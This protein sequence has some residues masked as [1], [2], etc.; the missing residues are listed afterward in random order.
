MEGDAKTQPY[1]FTDFSNDLN[2][3]REM[4]RK[5]I[6]EAYNTGWNSRKYGYN[7]NYYTETFKQP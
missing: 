6:E 7:D 2:T 4:H 1:S 3:A 5:E